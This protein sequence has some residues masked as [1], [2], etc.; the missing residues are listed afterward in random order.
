MPGVILLLDCYQARIIVTVD[1]TLPVSVVP[2]PFIHVPP[3][4]LS[5]TPSKIREFQNQHVRH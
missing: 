4:F 1:D 3:N 2:D 5:S